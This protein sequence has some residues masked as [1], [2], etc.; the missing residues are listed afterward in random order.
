M[1]IIAL[2]NQKGGV[3][4]TT[5]AVNLATALSACRKKVLLIDFDPQ[6]NA[7][8]A[9]HAI[10][11]DFTSYSILRFPEEIKNA[12]H[13]TS[14]PY[15]YHI[16]GARDLAGVDIEFAH[17]NEKEFLL[18]RALQQCKENFDFIFIDCPPSLNLLTVNALSCADSIIVPM[19]CEFYALE[20][21]T[22]LLENISTIRRN[23][24]NK[25]I[26]EGIIITM[27]DSRPTLSQDVIND[28]KK[29]L[30]NQLYET[31]I[32]RNIRVAEAPSHGKPILLYD[33]QSRGA[34]AYVQLAGEFLRRRVVRGETT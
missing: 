7:G 27:Y 22:Y 26:L 30:P 31:K 20:G 5:T 12:I 32:P 2:A 18:K 28:I 11:S 14:I 1:E 16:K 23:I 15:L 21:L 9:V 8:T 10:E 24:N 13:E 34:Q 25:L 33:I 19:L 6:M 29:Y 4:K 3:G 17:T